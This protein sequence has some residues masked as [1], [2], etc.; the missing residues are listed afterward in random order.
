MCAQFYAAENERTQAVMKNK[1]KVGLALSSGSMWGL[2]HIGVLEILE[3]HNI[4]IHMI[5]GT[6]MGSVVAG[7]YASGR[8]TKFMRQLAESI[9]TSEEMR[10]TD[11]TVPRMGMIKGKKIEQAIYTLCGGA[12]IENLKIPYRAVACCVEENSTAV[13]KSGDLTSAIRCS[14]AIPGIFEPVVKDGKTYVDGAVLDRVPVNEVREMG[15]DYII[16]VDVNSSGG[17]N[18]S[19]KNIFHLLLTVFEMMEWQATEHKITNADTV[20]QPAVRHI[21]P[22]SFKQAKECIDLGRNAAL[23]V[24]EDVKRDLTAMG[25]SF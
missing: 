17:T 12:K 3:E 25:Y 18:N 11:I 21:N 15:A 14:I 23:E 22:V 1:I 20:I 7:L 6:S 13:F 9:T 19:P 5:A 10:Y 16:A 4:P 8:T 24:I 2:A